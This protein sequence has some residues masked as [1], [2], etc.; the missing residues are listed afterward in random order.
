MCRT[1][2]TMT[3]NINKILVL[4]GC[5]FATVFSYAQET[6]SQPSRAYAQPTAENVIVNEIMVSNL[7][8]FLDRSGDYGGYIELYNPTDENVRLM[9]MFISDDPENLTKFRL[10]AS[11]GSIPAHGHALIWFDHNGSGGKYLGD[12]TAQAPWKLDYDGG[13]IYISRRDSQLVV[14][15]KYPRA[16]S[17]V[18][19]S[20]TTDGGDTWGYTSVPT[21][22]Y[23]N[24]TTGYATTQLASPV[25]DTDAQLFGSSFTIHVAYPDGA[26]LRYTTDG[27]TP[28]LT[29]GTTSASG[30]FR[31]S[32]GS[33][34]IYRF[35]C[36]QEGYLPSEVVTRSYIYKNKS[37]TL[38]I[39]SLC[40]DDRNFYND[41]IGIF[42]KGISN[43]YEYDWDRPVN[44]E[45]I[46]TTGVV[47]INT[48]CDIA[49]SGAFS[50][51]FNPRPFRIK[52]NKLYSGRSTFDAHF[53]N[54]K[55][56]LKT[57][58]LKFRNGGNDVEHRI[59]DGAV[60]EII[61]RSGFYLDGQL[62]SP[63]HVFV[64]GKYHGMLNMREPSNKF[65][66]YSN[67]GIDTDNIDAFEYDPTYG[68]V[69][70][71]GDKEVFMK[72]YNLTYNCE[73]DAVYEEIC[74]IVDIDEYCNYMAAQCWL[75]GNDWIT[76][77]NNAKGFRER[78]ED[79]RF[80]F[81][82]YDV[83]AVF[84]YTDLFSQLKKKVDSSKY[85][86][87]KNF[88]IQSLLNLLNNNTFKKKFVTAYCLVAGSVF[89]PE[90][91]TAIVDEL[92]ALIKP[93]LALEGK[94]P[95]SQAEEVKKQIKSST[96][97]NERMT[98][99]SNFLSL[100][101]SKDMKFK[102]TLPEARFL[103]NDNFVPTSRFDGRLYG[104]QVI[105][106]FAPA[107]Y[108]FVGWRK[109]EGGSIISTKR[110]LSFSSIA[111][112]DLVAEFEPIAENEMY[113]ACA[114]PVV[115]NE[116][117]A[118]NTVFCNDYY[119]RNDWIELYNNTSEEIDISGMYL[120][121][122]ENNLHKYQIISSSDV[123]TIIPP[124]GFL[125]VWCDKLDP[126]AELHASFK[127]ANDNYECVYLTAED[128]SWTDRFQYVKHVGS[129]SVGRFPDGGS[130][131]FEMTKPT[132]GESNT[133]TSQ[134]HLLYGSN[135]D[136]VPGTIDDIDETIFV[137]GGDC[138]YYS[139]SGI[140]LPSAQKGLNIIRDVDGRVRKVMVK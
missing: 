51:S 120:S 126:L 46:D 21:P 139:P 83:D 116:V 59:K 48:E 32:T 27:S 9:N 82:M 71:D 72:F 17:R 55:R 56:Y 37:Y 122:N 97:R 137:G 86:G 64:N 44:F 49:C 69:Q 131:V 85:V 140:L 2:L 1:K 12:A 80:H 40:S 47:L 29:N 11:N 136:H 10:Q 87:G 23:A 62:Y 132:V 92:A 61:Q 8:M 89:E 129:H 130:C 57:K 119:K 134:S 84:S 35:R 42:V 114:Y 52:S 121:D 128:D 115:I 14:S 75:G 125:V 3:L 26:T 38:P 5:I 98:A 45:Y 25:P 30:T 117:S 65:F 111:T 93:A 133:Y 138:Q 112:T 39:V 60:Q 28:T 15:Q 66:A 79:G 43:N 7:D 67:Y 41:S 118:S 103:L 53:F 33:S 91:S 54:A 123:P 127:L 110:R 70:K 90:R 18:S 96:K 100:S 102:S 50:R 108:N 99:L 105:E 104:G 81:V 20:R 101:S 63:A 58:N 124:H 113:N 6:S 95:T 4:A 94:S 74:R 16:Y 109:G 107:G 135:E 22:G 68:Y 36:F 73:D 106:A 13:T 34:K 19:Y 77:D 78:S 31:V 24:A 76:N 88:L